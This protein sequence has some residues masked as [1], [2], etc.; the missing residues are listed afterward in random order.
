MKE[1]S[2]D[3]LITLYHSDTIDAR[4]QLNEILRKHPNLRAEFSAYLFD[5]ELLREELKVLEIENFI[6]PEPTMPLKKS[7]TKKGN[8][9]HHITWFSMGAAAVALI[10]FSTT[11]LHQSSEQPGNSS[12]PIITQNQPQT[13]DDWIAK[14]SD[15]APN[16]SWN[17]AP[18][19]SIGSEF[20]QGTYELK[21]GLAQLTFSSD[22]ELV[23]KA[24]TRFEII[25]NM[26]VILHE[27]SMRAH[28]GERGYGFIINTPDTKIRDL[29]TE[30]GV[31]VSQNQETD[32]HV[33]TGEVE[34]HSEQ[35][36]TPTL[37]QDGYAARWKNGST[38]TQLK[39]NESLYPTKHTIARQRWI[40][41]RQKT[42]SDP[43]LTAFFDFS[44]KST[45]LP[46]A[47]GNSIPAATLHSPTWVSGRWQDHAAL[48]FDQD[49]QWAQ[50][51]LPNY[52][53]SFT[54]QLWVRID[55][56]PNALNTLLN[57]PEWKP[58][59]HHWQLTNN[60]NLRVGLGGPHGYAITSR[61]NS[62]SAGQWTQL[63]T[64][65]NSNTKT[66][67]YYINDQLALNH[68]NHYAE[69]IFGKCQM[70]VWRSHGSPS[71]TLRG[72]IDEFTIRERC[73]TPQ[74]IAD[75]YHIGKPF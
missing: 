29:G 13:E 23:I 55:H 42:L 22:V 7:L 20:Q 69:I 36:D 24:P 45:D 63:T 71:R 27:G 31:T 68:H 59:A 16:T 61:G 30:F 52:Q 4:S 21:S 74:E 65:Y 34:I 10:G 8:I 67:S 58:A 19:A 40:E 25:D 35:H 70:G 56:F 18:N 14:F 54:F 64:T 60:G 12:P 2:I 37:A 32:V 38:V 46:N 53:T 6:G 11:M 50:F 3:D 75:S 48:L 51:E 44:A 1:Y 15:A 41:A 33:F 26:K 9:I 5:E 62:V 39:Q 57:S 43:S 73:L 49:D 47:A 66:L 28:V 72:K 17:L